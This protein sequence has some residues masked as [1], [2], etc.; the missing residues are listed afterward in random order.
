MQNSHNNWYI[1]Y[2]AATDFIVKTKPNSN[3][4]GLFTII[5]AKLLN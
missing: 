1:L 2:V 5:I 3:K 4:T